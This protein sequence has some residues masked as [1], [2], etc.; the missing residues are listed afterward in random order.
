VEAD[1]RTYTIYYPNQLPDI[2]LRWPNAPEE[3]SYELEIDGKRET[4]SAPEHLLKSGTLKDG[5]HQLSFH[6][7]TRRSRT[8]TVE[9]RFDN[10]A[11]TASLNEPADRS[12][13]P[14]TEIKVA[15]VA[16]PTWKV[17]LEGGTIAKL[18]DGRFEGAIATTPDRPD[19]VVRLAHPRLGTHY[20]LRRAASSP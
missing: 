1:G 15:G 19:I 11:P 9:V 5:I 10:N 6:G 20:Y 13:T 18:S 3:T 4:V 2:S 7:M 12:F 16:L 14:G 8:T 17:S